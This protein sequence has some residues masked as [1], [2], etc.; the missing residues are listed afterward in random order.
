LLGFDV[1]LYDER[2]HG[3]SGGPNCTL[4]YYEKSDLHAVVDDLFARFGN[5]LFLGTYGESM[6]AA[7][8]LLEQ[9][10][11][12]RIRFV[13]SDCA[14]ASMH[15]QIVHLVRRIGF[16]PVR[17]S[18]CVGERFF[19]WMTKAD[20]ATVRP[21]DAVRRA[22]CPILFVHGESDE[23]IPPEASRRLFDACASAKEIYIAGNGA[24]HAESY[25]M[26]RGEYEEVFLR[27][28]NEKVLER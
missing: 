25:R 7:T 8:A 13:V 15:D 19:R 11:D 12:D 2:F 6:G 26:N 3:E 28:M 20:P 17:L 24:R 21:I 23:Y 27:F 5:N 4:G 1:V 14:F 18:A 9:A 10:E 16:L 22:R